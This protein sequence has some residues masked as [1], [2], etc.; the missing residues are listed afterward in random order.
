[1]GD[2]QVTVKNLQVVRVLP[3]DNLLLIRGGVPGAVN[4]LLRITRA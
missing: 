3:E 1:M 2:Q 4:G